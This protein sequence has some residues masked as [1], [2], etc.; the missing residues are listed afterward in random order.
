MKSAGFDQKAINEFVA[1]VN[2]GSITDQEIEKTMKTIE[3][4]SNLS[5]EQKKKLAETLKSGDLQSQG[6]K[7][8][9]LKELAH[10]SDV[11]K[12]KQDLTVRK[13]AVF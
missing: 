2:S 11:L 5:D 13:S 1:K 10:L 9:V 8:K 7:P 4:K 6:L 12:Q 3:K